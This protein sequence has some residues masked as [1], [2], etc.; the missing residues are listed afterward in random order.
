VAEA[1]EAREAH[2]AWDSFQPRFAQTRKADARFVD[3][4]ERAIRVASDDRSLVLAGYAAFH[5]RVRAGFY[6]DVQRDGEFRDLAGRWR[7]LAGSVWDKPWFA[8]QQ[9]GLLLDFHAAVPARD[10]EETVRRV[11]ELDELTARSFR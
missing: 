8:E 5:T 3:E 9:L 4:E 2:A 11:K 7:S 6:A 1:R 10:A